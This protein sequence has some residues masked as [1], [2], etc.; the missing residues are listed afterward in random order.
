MREEREG[1]FSQLFYVV[2]CIPEEEEEADSLA[3]A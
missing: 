3:V 1:D 2:I